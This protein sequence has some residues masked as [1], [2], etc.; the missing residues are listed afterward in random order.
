MSTIDSTYRAQVKTLC[1]ANLPGI[2]SEDQIYWVPQLNR[3][4]VQELF[5]SGDLSAPFVTIALGATSQEDTAGDVM[6]YRQ[7]TAIYYVFDETDPGAYKNGVDASAGYDPIQYAS[8][9]G[10]AMKA[11]IRAY[12]GTAFAMWGDEA[13]FDSSDENAANHVIYLSERA[14]YSVA[15]TLNPMLGDFGA[16]QG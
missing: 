14:F 10:L 16:I 12:S 4:N 8:N 15:I 13:Q 7:P 1:I 2:T 6:T 5:N 9:I 3:E 11:A